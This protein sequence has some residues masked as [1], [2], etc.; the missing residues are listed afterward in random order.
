MCINLA[1]DDL[2]AISVL[3]MEGRGSSIA[4]A[5]TKKHAVSDGV[6]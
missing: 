5:F 4:S 6:M 3:R 2:E 1:R